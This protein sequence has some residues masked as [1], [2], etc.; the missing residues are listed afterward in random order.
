MRA[1]AATRQVQAVCICHAGPLLTLQRRRGHL[2]KAAM[3][4]SAAPR[5]VQAVCGCMRALSRPATLNG[6]HQRDRTACR[7]S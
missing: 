5:Q 7:Y 6:V 2:T 4:A 3:R 1:S